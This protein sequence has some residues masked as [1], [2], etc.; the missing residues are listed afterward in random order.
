M[1]VRSANICDAQAVFCLCVSFRLGTCLWQTVPLCVFQLF[2]HS[3]LQ[4]AALSR[5]IKRLCS[6]LCWMLWEE[7][8]RA[9][10]RY[11]HCVN[12]CVCLKQ[13]W[14]ISM[15]KHTVIIPVCFSLYT[16]CEEWLHFSPG[17]SGEN[18]PQS[19]R[20]QRPGAAH[21]L[22]WSW[23]RLLWERETHSGRGTAI[24]VLK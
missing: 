23:V 8:W 4:W 24:L 10:Q 16:E 17:L 18:L 19:L 13:L 2:L 20:V 21:Q 6:T 7:G 15:H 3:W 11:T 1:Q 14:L 12:L 22:L 9:K 5:N